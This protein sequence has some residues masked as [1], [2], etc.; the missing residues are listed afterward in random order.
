M[1]YWTCPECGAN[2]DPGEQCDCKKVEAAPLQRKRPP[3]K[4]ST[5]ILS[6]SR[7]EVKRE[8]RCMNG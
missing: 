4:I 1:H 6:A 2:L 5:A 7:Q 3:A 8:R